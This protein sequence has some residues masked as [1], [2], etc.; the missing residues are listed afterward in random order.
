MVKPNE[1]A[2]RG[3]SERSRRAL[4]VMIQLIVWTASFLGAFL[5]RFDFTIPSAFVST[6]LVGL[7]VLLTLRAAFCARVG[8]FRDLWRYTGTRDILALAKATGLS[9]AAF[10]LFAVFALKGF[11]RSIFIIDWLAGFLAVGGLRLGTRLTREVSHASQ[12]IGIARRKVL[13]VGAG[14]AG[15]SL[16][17]ELHRS[18][19][20]RYEVAGLV[21]DDPSKVGAHIHGVRVLGTIE[22]GPHLA[23]LHGVDEI[24]VAIPS[25]T[26][27]QMRRIVDVFRPCAVNVRTIP[28]LDQLIDGRVFTSQIRSVAID[29]L[30]GREPVTLDLGAIGQMVSGQTILVTGAGGS[31]GSEICRQIAR[32]NPAALVLMEQ[33]EN[34][35]Y[36]I[37]RELSERFPAVTSI[38]FIADVCDRKRVDQAFSA[39]RPTLILHAAAHKHVPMMELNPGEAIKNNVFGSKNLADA[40][41]ATGV[42]RFVMIS[43][44]KAV[45]PT[46]IMGAS[47]RIAEIY[48]QSLAQRSKTCF[49]TVRF[50]NVLGSNGSVIPLFLEQIARGGPITVT[51]P[52]MKRYFMTISEASQ[53]VLQAASMGRGGELFI[54]DM[55]EPVRI[56][57]LARDLVTLSGLTL[58]EDI[59]IRF[60]GMRPGEKL[61]EELSVESENA[62]K[63]RHP[64]IYVGKQR[65]VMLES[66]VRHLSEL[67]ALG[68]GTNEQALRAKIQEIV[69]E[70]AGAARTSTNSGS[71][72]ASGADV[73]PLRSA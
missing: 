70:Y 56:L 20:A 30:L 64:K 26:G 13:I 12:S 71:G 68:E 4:G 2:S 31:I 47:K 59:E 9:T 3:V 54:L 41:D 69:P 50:G 5:L 72:E 6:I 17:R 19:A 33:A 28:G 7:P 15:E 32:F 63:T 48:V 42:E 35:L 61:F 8:L 43:T 25:A 36:E 65:T 58:D 53:L 23:R 24:I 34:A 11:P 1:A 18:H 73:I 45:N 39:Y 21:D 62:D 49:V 16:L 14:N 27:R 44:D 10:V 38:P 29:D 55:G 40:A 60:T 46:S 67:Q 57:D 66:V 37:Q 51:H 52:E 22:N